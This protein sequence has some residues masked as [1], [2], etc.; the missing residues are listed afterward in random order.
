VNDNGQIM[1][2]ASTNGV[3]FNKGNLNETPHFITLMW[4][5]YRWTGDKSLINQHYPEIKKGVDWITNQQDQ[6]KN[7][8]PD[9]P[10]MMEIHGLHSEMIDVVVYTQQALVSASKIAKAVGD[11]T[12][13]ATYNNAAISLANKINEEWWVATDSSYA[14]FRATKAQ[15][16]ELIKAAI[17]RADTINKPHA[18]KELEAKLE[19]LKK[20]KNSGVQSFVV[21]HNWVVNTPMETKIAT[22]ENAKLALA[23][24]ANYTNKFGIYVTGMDRDQND[25]NR[26]KWSTFSY[27]GSVMTLPTGVQAVSEAQYGNSDQARNYLK[28]LFNSF[29][30]T[31]P[32]TMYEVS[33]DYGQIVQAWNIYGVAVPTVNYFFGIIPNAHNNEVTIKPQF[34]T[35]WTNAEIKKVKIGDEQLSIKM[36]ILEDVTSY[37][38]AISNPQWKV[39]LELPCNTAV[40]EVNGKVVEISNTT[41][42][43]IGSLK[44]I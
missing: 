16:L 8:Y 22:P 42:M 2:E 14:D 44:D 21:H 27:V 13:A 40:L 33:P 6:D 36:E 38:I 24:G 1:H 39:N 23:K 4:D 15:A 7:G 19:T 9:G 26:E 43:Y 30:Y 3:V 17:V 20:S 11:T 25:M 18:K 31:T 12:A 34:P 32:G 28:Q 5:Y 37:T 29:S 41:K 10:G 35:D